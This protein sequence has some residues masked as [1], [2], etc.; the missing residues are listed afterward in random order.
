MQ[1]KKEDIRKVV[2]H[3]IFTTSNF[4]S[5]LMFV[6]TDRDYAIKRSY[7]YERWKNVAEQRAKLK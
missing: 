1:S 3:F 2:A 7:R 5:M 6:L 4:T